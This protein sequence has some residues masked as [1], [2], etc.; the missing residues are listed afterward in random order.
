MSHSGVMPE[1]YFMNVTVNKTRDVDY[2][3]CDDALGEGELNAFT[4][5]P[6]TY[7][8]P[9]TVFTILT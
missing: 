7:A 1:V 4:E 5:Q 9:Y 2:I 3:H 8:C 6:C